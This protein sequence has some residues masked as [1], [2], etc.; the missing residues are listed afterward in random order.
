MKRITGVLILLF[1][2]GLM[3][4]GWGIYSPRRRRANTYFFKGMDL[5]KEK[6]YKPAISQIR[7]AMI[8][9]PSYGMYPFWAGRIYMN[10]L[11]QYSAAVGYLNK[12][13][14]LMPAN[15]WPLTE[16]AKAYRKAKRYRQA[17]K[18][19]RRALKHYKRRKRLPLYRL[20]EGLGQVLRDNLKKP[21]AA[22]KIF[23]Q[24]FRIYYHRVH[25]LLEIAKC[26][27]DLKYKKSCI[28]TVR[29]A[30]KLAK[31]WY[32]RMPYWLEWKLA[33]IL[34][35]RLKHPRAAIRFLKK[36]VKRNRRQPYL[37]MQMAYAY[38][39]L[40]QFRWTGRYYKK[41]L[42]LYAK[43]Q[44]KH[45]VWYYFYLTGLLRTKLK[46]PRQA[47]IWLKKAKKLYP[48]EARIETGLG[49]AYGKLKQYGL[50]VKS[51]K[52]HLNMMKTQKKKASMW[53]YYYL[54]NT[55][56]AK[57]KQPGKALVYL[58]QAA[59]LYP[60]QGRI[61]EWMGY[62]YGALKQYKKQAAAYMRYIR[63]LLKA[64]KKPS[65]WRMCNM[66]DILR[67]KLK[68]PLESIAVLKQAARIHAKYSGIPVRIG[69]AYGVLKNYTQ[70]ILY[71]RRYV[72][73]LVKAGKKPSAWRMCNMGDILRGR[74]KKPKESIAVLRKAA[75]FHPKYA[76]I[77]V[78]LGNAYGVL[79][80][81]RKQVY[82]YQQYIRLV[83]AKKSK[84]NAWRMVV[85]AS[86]L[87]NKLKQ[88]AVALKILR[89][90]SRLHPGNWNFPIH[91]GGTYSALKSWVK[92]A[93]AYRRAIFLRKRSGKK[94]PGWLKYRW[95]KA[96]KKSRR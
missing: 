80:Q 26:Y 21:K 38:K 56:R 1:S 37:I 78:R 49:H 67:S 46:Q 24:G 25:L 28:K 92:A 54:A 91:L 22:L 69:H 59:K 79:K 11:K 7:K 35:R 57:L 44:I 75:R 64:G 84:P 9:D 43:L 34:R 33:K 66:G 60:K 90:G 83:L 74:L 55:L 32:L 76:G 19:Y 58:L 27:A 42:S 31:K 30:V 41:A 40:K 82:Y 63:L 77:P 62:C 13:A 29:K 96:V 52:N 6:K 5:C 16:L 70:Q 51:Y 14:R 36:A 20:Y 3:L 65:A 93:N 39:D 85:T 50:Q 71:Y 12:A 89:K 15:P 18:T 86:I 81:Y 53:I 47:V 4:S 68:K 48:D 10:R 23:R 88:P 61:R 95:K 94:V 73:I 2:S 72:N 87:R 17:V 8:I 45:S